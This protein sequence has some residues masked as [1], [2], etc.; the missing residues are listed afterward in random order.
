MFTYTSKHCLCWL[1]VAEVLV[2][3][4]SKWYLL[5]FFST[6]RFP[7]SRYCW[8]HISTVL[9]YAENSL[10]FFP[11]ERIRTWICYWKPLSTN[12]FPFFSNSLFIYNF[13]IF[14]GGGR[15]LRF[16]RRASYFYC[17]FSLYKKIPCDLRVCN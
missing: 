13:Y 1:S 12:H 15:V 8:N 10:Y 9:L 16:E 17:I 3:S 14:V 2:I 11:I 7:A 5:L 4:L 6:G